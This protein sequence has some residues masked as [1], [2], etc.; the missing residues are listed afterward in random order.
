M[1]KIDDQLDLAKLQDAKQGFILNIRS[2]V[3]RVHRAGCE[4]VGAM[5]TSAYQK[6]FFEGPREDV[7]ASLD[8]SWGASGW[9]SCGRCGGIG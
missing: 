5:V 3:K 7:R 4:A 2:E 6:E 1:R 8:T 9:T